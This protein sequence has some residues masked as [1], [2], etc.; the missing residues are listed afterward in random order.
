MHIFVNSNVEY[1]GEHRS[2]W[3][4]FKP[5]LFCIIIELTLIYLKG[6]LEQACF[7]GH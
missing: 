5:F 2:S 6:Q 7:F 3:R 1:L 4:Y